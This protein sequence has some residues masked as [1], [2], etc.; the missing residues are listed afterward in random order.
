MP[1]NKILLKNIVQDKIEEISLK[2][3]RSAAA[4]RVAQVRDPKFKG[5]EVPIYKAGTKEQIGTRRKP[6]KG[7]LAKR[8]AK[9]YSKDKIGS[10]PLDIPSKKREDSSSQPV[11][12]RMAELLIERNLFRDI[13][14]G[15]KGLV[16]GLLGTQKDRRDPSKI[17]KSSRFIGSAVGTPARAI[18]KGGLNLVGSGL[19]KAGD[20]ASGLK[21]KVKLNSILKQRELKKQ[22]LIQQQKDKE[23][24]EY[25]A[26]PMM[27]GLV[28]KNA[29]RIGKTERKPGQETKAQ[30]KVAAKNRQTKSAVLSNAVKSV[31]PQFSGMSASRLNINIP[32]NAVAG[33]SGRKAYANLASNVKKEKETQKAKD[34]FNKLV[35]DDGG[36]AREKKRKFNDAAAAT[37]KQRQ[38]YY[39]GDGRESTSYRN[40]MLQKI[41]EMRLVEKL[42]EGENINE[43]VWMIPSIIRAAQ[44]GMGAYRAYKGAR[45]IGTA[46]NLIKS[47]SPGAAIRG[48]AGY[49]VRAAAGKGVGSLA[50]SAAKKGVGKAIAK[51]A[52]EMVGKAGKAVGSTVSTVGKAT[53][54]AKK[55]VG[56]EKKQPKEQEPSPQ[57]DTNP[58]TGMDDYRGYPKVGDNDEDQ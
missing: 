6:G 17:Y 37:E 12:D 50:G 30:R 2:T 5:E 26:L 44:L 57:S 48:L 24:R 14:K 28:D 42:P 54:V 21:R 20:V 35:P 38:F 41:A 15:G 51:A 9:H 29:N 40:I 1:I 33:P 19:S 11:Y 39:G 56:G 18:L 47:G 4:K 55:L 13:Y 10:A 45:A 31:V 27:P 16:G 46:A 23:K 49:G 8:I 53:G 36:S 58:H 22:Q 43:W 7:V 52:G 25:D 32:K 34:D 3:R